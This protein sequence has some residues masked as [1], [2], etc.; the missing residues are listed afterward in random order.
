MDCASFRDSVAFAS[1]SLLVG[2]RGIAP[3]ERVALETRDANPTVS[4]SK[5][6]C[7]GKSSIE[8]LKRET[9]AK[10]GAMHPYHPRSTRL[11]PHL[12]HP[13]SALK[14]ERFRHNP[15][16]QRVL[17]EEKKNAAFETSGDQAPA[18]YTRLRIKY[19]RRRQN[20]VHKI[21]GKNMRRRER[22]TERCQ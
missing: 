21:C 3:I 13:F 1:Q 4:P 8:V 15:D 6:G 16:R 7:W 11:P 19:E 2:E 9:P 22:V 5:I 18:S 20:L 14:S 10:K 17:R 12:A